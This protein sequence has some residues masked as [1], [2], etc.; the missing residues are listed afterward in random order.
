[1]T[2]ALP[3]LPVIVPFITAILCLFTW[4]SVIAQRWITA[5]GMATLFVVASALLVTVDQEGIQVMQVGDFRAPFG[6]S[7]VAD[8]LSASMVTITGLMGM[9]IALYSFASIEMERQAFGYYPLYN[10]MIMGVCG[11]FLTGDLFNLYVWFE[12]LLMSSFV[13]LA[14]GGEQRQLAGAIQYVTVNLISSTLFLIAVGMIYATVGTLN[15]ADIAVKMPLVEQENVVNALGFMLLISFGIKA[16]IFPLFFW[17]P[18]SYDVPPVSVSAIFAALLTKVGVYALIR[19]T[20]LIFLLD[21]DFIRGLLMVVAGCTMV[22]GVM[23]AATEYEFRRI[24]SF[25][26]VSQIGYMVMGIALATP[27]ALAGTI[28]FILH[29]IIAKSNLFLV[30]GVVQ[31]LRGTYQLKELGGL[32][33]AYPF[34]AIC[35]LIPALGLAGIPPLSGFWGKFVLVQAGLESEAYVIVAVSLFVSVWTLYS[36]MKIWAEVFLKSLPESAPPLSTELPPPP[37]RIMMLPIV[38]LALITI[39]MGILAEPFFDLLLRAG[40]QLDNPTEYIEAVLGL[41]PVEG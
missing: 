4:K 30:S 15:M 33:K 26:I 27:L 2:N 40:E 11:A 21:G 14:L 32:G 9:L 10:I 3:V 34:L 39:G 31:R 1:M 24:L 13:L 35:F 22:I 8:L 38:V 28:Y 20:T 16:A 23:G 5:L 17:L 6:I 12:V 29:N 18:V 37:I 19:T 36:M 41:Y 25:H 7:L